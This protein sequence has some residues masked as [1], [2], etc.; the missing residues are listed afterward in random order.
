MVV[1]VSLRSWMAARKARGF[2]RAW[3]SGAASSTV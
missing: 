2:T 1:A 3:M